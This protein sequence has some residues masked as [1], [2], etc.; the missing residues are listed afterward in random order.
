VSVS[1]PHEVVFKHLARYL[2]PHTA[3]TAIKTF[4]ERALKRT[5][6]QVS[7]Q[8]APGLLQALRPMMRTLIGADECEAVLRDIGRELGL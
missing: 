8:D 3:R 7:L 6:E 1:A 4:A 2:G 5:P